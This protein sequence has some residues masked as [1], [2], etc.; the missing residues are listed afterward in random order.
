MRARILVFSSGTG[1]EAACVM[2]FVMPLRISDCEETVAST[3]GDL[4][5][6]P[7]AEDCE[8]S[9]ESCQGSTSGVEG[10][11]GAMFSGVVSSSDPVLISL[12]S[13]YQ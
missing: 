11:C 1:N 4:C 2:W 3:Y 5:D 8:G 10:I 9:F 12:R 7:P 13:R 6:W